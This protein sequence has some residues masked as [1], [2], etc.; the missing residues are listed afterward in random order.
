MF[1]DC[2]LLMNILDM[3]SEFQVAKANRYNNLRVIHEQL[4]IR[5]VEITKK[6]YFLELRMNQTINTSLQLRPGFK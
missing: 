3:R 1:F 2:F 5:D 4:N 6:L